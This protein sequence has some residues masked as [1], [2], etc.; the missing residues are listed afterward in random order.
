MKI[1]GIDSQDHEIAINGEL[2]FFGVLAMYYEEISEHWNEDTKETYGMHFQ[3]LILPYFAGRPLRAF[4]NVEKFQQIIE[5]IRKNG[6]LRSK[7]HE[8][9]GES[10]L[11]HFRHLIKKVVDVAAKHGVCPNALWGSGFQEADSYGEDPYAKKEKER[12]RLPRSIDPA[13]YVQILRL[14]M[15][16]P[17]QDGLQMALLLMC[18]FGLR[19]KEACSI[20]WEDIE[21]IPNHSGCYALVV[22]ST[23]E[24][25]GL[26]RRSGG[27]T[28]NMYRKIPIPSKVYEFLMARKAFI[29]RKLLEQKA[30]C[31]Q[32]ILHLP[33]ACN[34]D[35]FGEHCL[36]AQ[37]STAGREIFRK[38]GFSEEAFRAAEIESG[39]D[40]SGFPGVKS[41][42]AYTFRREFCTARYAL[43]YTP[44]EIAYCMG[45]KISDASIKRRY[46]SNPDNL[47]VLWTKA[48]AQPLLDVNDKIVK[49]FCGESLFLENVT[50]VR[51]DFS[52]YTEDV[53][54]RVVANEPFD[55]PIFTIRTENEVSYS[56]DCQK[57]IRK[58]AKEVNILSE[59]N[60]LH[61]RAMAREKVSK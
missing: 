20:W 5:A 34:R 49:R 7:G 11:R 50:D 22:H 37:I 58:G 15:T 9:Y 13:N 3:E 1:P 33:I 30:E 27:K 61:K 45:H 31:Y 35:A 51:V 25:R 28:V 16:D 60:Y 19:N 48:A 57:S 24:C 38:V 47:Y 14:L 26:Y 12:M 42:T 29:Q 21:E 46:F 52:E 23:A 6:T 54:V 40:D 4:D 53:R 44:D 39:E 17:Q 59:Y 18:V 55:A 10:T 8:E 36:P 56:V 43:G 32:D 2:T 41:P